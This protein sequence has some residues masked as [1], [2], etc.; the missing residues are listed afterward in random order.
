MHREFIQYV[1][2]NADCVVVG[3]RLSTI[4]RYIITNAA[5]VWVTLGTWVSNL[6][7]LSRIVYCSVVQL[8]GLDRLY[9]C[10]VEYIALFL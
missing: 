2:F 6:V 4:C 8:R 3:T 7:Q 10:T 9:L 5:L 1:I